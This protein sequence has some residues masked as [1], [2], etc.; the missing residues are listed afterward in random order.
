MHGVVAVGEI[1]VARVAIAGIATALVLAGPGSSSHGD[2]G[3]NHLTTAGLVREPHRALAVDHHQVDAELGTASGLP[4]R[5]VEGRRAC[6]R[7]PTHVGHHVAGTT[8]R[9]VEAAAVGTRGHPAGVPQVIASTAEL[10]LGHTRLRHEGRHVAVAAHAARRA[11]R[12]LIGRAGTGHGRGV[13]VVS[14]IAGIDVRV[15]AAVV[16]RHDVRVGHAAVSV[17]HGAAVGVHVHGAGATGEKGRERGREDQ[18]QLT[19]LHHDPLHLERALGFPDH[20]DFLTRLYHVVSQPNHIFNKMSIG[21]DRN[22]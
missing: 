13:A 5:V 10:R 20:R 4:E 11:G 17:G 8:Q 22:F 9:Q 12:D 1:C 2:R 14:G 21:Y 15:G 7:E 16:R 19:V 6:A 18:A 3:A